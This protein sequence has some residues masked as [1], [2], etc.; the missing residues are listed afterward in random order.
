MNYRIKI[1]QFQLFGE[2]FYSKEVNIMKMFGHFSK[3]GSLQEVSV[4]RTGSEDRWENQQLIDEQIF[5]EWLL[6]AGQSTVVM[7]IEY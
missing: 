2:Y 4:G 1:A 6:Y 5:T 7:Y 3:P